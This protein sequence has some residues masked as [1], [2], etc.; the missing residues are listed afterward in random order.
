MIGLLALIGIAHLPEKLAHITYGDQLELRPTIDANIGKEVR[1]TLWKSAPEECQPIIGNL[2]H[3]IKHITSKILPEL[4]ISGNVKFDDIWDEIDDVMNPFDQDQPYQGEVAQNDIEL[5]MKQFEHDNI[6]LSQYNS[7]QNLIRQNPSSSNNTT[8][9]NGREGGVI[10]MIKPKNQT[11]KGDYDTMESE[12][13]LFSQTGNESEISNLIKAKSGGL[14][15]RH[16]SGQ[17]A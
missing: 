3:A 16:A 2:F 17:E 1:D 9:R 12:I 11:Y 14:K 13:P 8:Q 15:G 6:G 10:D 7:N 4:P 5:Q